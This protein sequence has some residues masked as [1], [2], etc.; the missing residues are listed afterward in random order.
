MA[1]LKLEAQ[2]RK[3][4]GKKVDQLRRDGIIPAVIYGSSVKTVPIQVSYKQFEKL[5]GEAGE[6][7]LVDLTVDE[8]KAVAV[9]IQSVTRH[10]LTEKLEHVDFYQV[11]LTK[12]IIAE[13][14]LRFEGEAPAVKELNGTLV[15]SLDKIEVECLPQQLVPEIIVD[16]SSLKTF[17]DMI[18][19]SDLKIPEELELKD[20]PDEPVA[21]VQPPRS[22]KELEELDTEVQDDVDKVEK[23]E[24][25]K[26]DEEAEVEADQEQKAKP[27]EKESGGKE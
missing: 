20:N 14:E 2:S 3:V 10:P 8:G 18:H 12:K 17:D 27:G 9:L 4:L 7:S 16:V 15:K 11:D 5:Y 21:S 19:V 13:I 1:D 24:E 25:K 22:E 23:V 6:S 26:T